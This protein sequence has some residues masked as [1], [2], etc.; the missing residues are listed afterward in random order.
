MKYLL[1]ANTWIKFLNGRSERVR[2]RLESTPPDQITLCAIVK[3][4]LVYGAIKS[5]R[6][7]EN[8]ERI[9]TFTGNFVS[10][11][12]DDDAARIYGVLRTRLESVGKLIGPN[13]LLIAA[14]AL[15]RGATL[16]THNTR[17]FARVEGLILEDWE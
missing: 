2:Q 8:L 17:E 6:P 7:A 16:V 14:I 9:Q 3:A 15:A 1:D 11:P 5:A 12:F 4:E 10:F 13:D